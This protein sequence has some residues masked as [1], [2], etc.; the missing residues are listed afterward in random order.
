MKLSEIYRQLQLCAIACDKFSD[1]DKILII[2]KLH[3]EEVSAQWSE[4][5]KEREAAEAAK[6]EEVQA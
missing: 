4:E 3:M 6:E 2:N 1:E 5:R